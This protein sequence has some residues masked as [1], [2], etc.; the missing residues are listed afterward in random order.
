M[1]KPPVE[2]INTA[3]FWQRLPIVNRFQQFLA[4]SYVSPQHCVLITGNRGSGKKGMIENVVLPR[5]AEWRILVHD[6]SEHRKLPELPY[7][8]D[9]RSPKQFRFEQQELEMCFGM[10]HILLRIDRCPK[11]RGIDYIV[12]LLERA[13]KHREACL[14]IATTDH[15]IPALVSPGHTI[16]P[17]CCCEF[18]VPDWDAQNLPVFFNALDMAEIG[19]L[20]ESGEF[21]DLAEDLI[22]RTKGRLGLL[23]H[24][25]RVLRIKLNTVADS[26][27][28]FE[29]SLKQICI[30]S[31]RPRK[32]YAEQDRFH[33]LGP[34][35]EMGAAAH[36]SLSH[37]LANRIASD[38]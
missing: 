1:I 33:P 34:S 12:S 19:N 5:L 15:I 4:Q 16:P 21:S 18:T 23:M 20:I 24:F 36:D 3:L 13:K 26:K 22:K 9:F 31:A 32:K 25:G 17:E 28:A 2:M 37:T 30:P 8:T 10:A 27:V 11:G 6:C 38:N 29:E 35:P 7:S 14:V